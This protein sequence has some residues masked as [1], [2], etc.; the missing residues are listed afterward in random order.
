MLLFDTGM[1]VGDPYL[2]TRYRPSRRPL[3]QA[4]AD[5]GAP[6]GDIRYVVNCHLH[7][8]HCGGNP[9]LAGRPVF[10]QSTELSLAGGPNYTLPELID[11]DGVRYE[12]LAGETEILPDVWV[13]PTPGHTAGHQSLAI[14]CQ[15][16]TV[17]LAGQA[18]DSTSAFSGAQ[19]AW[20]AGREGVGDPLPVPPAW[21]DRLLDLDPKRVLFAH[22]N[23]VWEPAG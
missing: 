6:V 2:E 15:D 3:D 23:A 5:A 19:L 1:G 22:D 20:R 7:F 10:V 12:E 17:V 21:V 16:G 11:F 18:L 9:S 4:L 14:R 13:I 8:D